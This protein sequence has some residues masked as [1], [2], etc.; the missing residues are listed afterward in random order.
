MANGDADSIFNNLPGS[1]RRPKPPPGR[2]L[3]QELFPVDPRV[4]IGG[5]AAPLQRFNYDIA[6]G[7]LHP[8][9]AFANAQELGSNWAGQGAAW[10]ANKIGLPNPE[11]LGNDVTA[12]LQSPRTEGGAGPLTKK[13]VE[14]TARVA[15]FAVAPAFATGWAPGAWRKLSQLKQDNPGNADFIDGLANLTPDQARVM[16][17]FGSA[18]NNKFLDAVLNAHNDDISLVNRVR[19]GSPYASI[20]LREMRGQPF[21]DPG[22]IASLPQP[23]PMTAQE[24]LYGD[25]PTAIQPAS[26][27]W[28]TFSLHQPSMPPFSGNDPRAV[29]PSATPA[30]WPPPRTIGMTLNSPPQG[31]I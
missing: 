3:G 15:P 5:A 8:F 12:M 6:Q 24:F 2:G 18:Q 27:P 22:S 19:E 26:A 13:I 31:V 29:A 11:L 28:N 17:P 16:P 21:D 20:P 30:P 7:A 10:A 9:E 23:P 14:G 25:Q 1:P 4:V